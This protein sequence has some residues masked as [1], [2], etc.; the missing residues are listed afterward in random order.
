MS[1]SKHEIQRVKDTTDVVTLASRLGLEPI[2]RGRAWWCCCPY[3]DDRRPS[4]QLNQPDSGHPALHC[5]A[6]GTSADVV[7]LVQHV[8]RCDFRA[9]MQFLGARDDDGSTSAPPALV[10]PRQPAA[11]PPPPTPLPRQ[12]L[13]V[14][15][16]GRC[17]SALY[18]WLCQHLG[19]ASARDI[20]A[21]YQVGSTTDATA[22]ATTYHHP[23]PWAVYPYITPAGELAKIKYMRYNDDGHRDKQGSRATLIDQ[24]RNPLPA[25]FGGHLLGNDDTRP[26]AVV[27]SEKTALILADV[28]P[29]YLWVACGGASAIDTALDVV[30]T[31]APGRPVV[32][33]ADNDDAGQQWATDFEGIL[34][35]VDVAALASVLHVTSDRHDDIS[36]VVSRYLAATSAAGGAVASSPTATTSAAWRACASSPTTATTS[37]PAATDDTPAALLEGDSDARFWAQRWN[38]SDIA[39]FR[40]S[41]ALDFVA[42]EDEQPAATDDRQRAATWLQR[43]QV[44][45]DGG[46]R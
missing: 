39:A 32:L 22:G 42:V 44:E 15:H 5:Y 41:W 45:D 3:H 17:D 11:P 40:Q 18:A 19:T 1:F 21:L 46:P 29:D 28:L 8:A 13:D 37:A 7:A 4:A 25:V 27:E 20:V 10:I 43:L 6:C 38:D 34:R 14:C 16:P 33:Y 9:A 31:A 12:R 30:A 26:V 23:T 24:P 35:V 36:D 2:R